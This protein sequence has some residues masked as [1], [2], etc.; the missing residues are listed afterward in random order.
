ME[1]NLAHHA[2]HL[3]ERLP[4]ARV[5]RGDDLL[6]ADSG[7]A[8]DTFN[9]VAAARFAPDMAG[10]R[11]D[12]TV[13]RVRA[14]GRPFSWWVGPASA[15]ADLSARLADAGLPA[16]EHETAMWAELADDAVP[17]RPDVEGLSIER[18]RSLDQLADYA[19]VLSANWDPPAATVRRFFAYASEGALAA[20]CAARHLVGYVGR[21]PVATAEV[22]VSAGVAGIYNIC[23]LAGQ[24][25]RGYGGALTLAALHTARELGVR[26]AVLQASADGEPVYERLG[27]RACGRFTE[28]ALLP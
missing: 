9:V 18:V 7:L 8:D 6:I 2:C 24:R 28:H 19:A 15:L 23:T 16:S 22:F 10:A 13:R 26:T 4:G 12:E 5:D 17:P 3:H 1:Q 11:I 20:G 27:F 21:R 25:R 14:T